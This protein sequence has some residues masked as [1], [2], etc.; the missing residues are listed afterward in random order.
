MI[1]LSSTAAAKTTNTSLSVRQLNSVAKLTCSSHES[2]G[3]VRLMIWKR[4]NNITKNVRL[5]HLGEEAETRQ[6]AD[7]AVRLRR[8]T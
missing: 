5:T 1:R 7:D 3:R 6:T 8:T 4:A 2:S